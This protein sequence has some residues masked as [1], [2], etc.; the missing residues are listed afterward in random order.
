MVGIARARRFAACAK[1][2]IRS[3]HTCREMKL[4]ILCRPTA[5]IAAVLGR[6]KQLSI[7]SGACSTSMDCLPPVIR[8]PRLDH[9]IWHAVFY[10]VKV[11]GSSS[12]WTLNVRCRTPSWMRA[13]SSKQLAAVTLAGERRTR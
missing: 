10:V 5:S 8:P 1:A 11:E 4:R 12:R 7:W 9:W 2:A 13:C 6:L 3:S